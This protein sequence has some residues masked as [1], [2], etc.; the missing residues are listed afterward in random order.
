LNFVQDVL[1]YSYVFRR[2]HCV[3]FLHLL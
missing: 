1:V 2:G 3:D